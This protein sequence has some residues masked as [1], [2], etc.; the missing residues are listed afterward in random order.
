MFR[1]I[2]WSRRDFLK[3]AGILGTGLAL[4]GSTRL[5]ADEPAVIETPIDPQTLLPEIVDPDIRQGFEAATMKNILTTMVETE[6]PG[7]FWISGDGKSF[8]G[9]TWP[10]LDS[11]QMTGA[12]ML[13]GYKRIVLD[14]FE[15]VQ[16]SQRKDGH[17][18]FSIF[19]G[20]DE[21]DQTFGR[22]LDPKDVY[23]YAPKK[24][25]GQLA[26]SQMEP[27]KWIGMFKHWRI[28]SDPLGV[29]GPVSYL[30]TAGEIFNF[31]GSES[32]VKDKLATLEAAAKY[33][34]TK[35]NSAG[36]VAGSGYYIEKPARWGSDGVTQCYVVRAF[37]EMARL[38]RAVGDKAK[39]QLWLG[40]AEKL[41]KTFRDIFW[42]EDHFAEYVHVQRGVIDTHGL[43]DSNWAAVAFDVATDEQI[44]K[45]WPKL[46][47]DPDF[48]Y[49]G[50][51]TQIVTKPTT[52]E[53]WE[54]GEPM[55]FPIGP[56]LYDAAAMGRVWYLEAMACVRMKETKRLVES[57]RKV[58]QAGIKEGGYWYERYRVQPDGT[59]SHEGPKAYAEYA[60]I[61]TR[62]VLGNRNLFFKKQT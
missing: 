12:Y 38:F 34:L 2:D 7:F 61:L 51:P 44:A 62:V 35:K 30:L 33:I 46:M 15:F 50:M 39:E 4:A 25:P 19:P 26:V 45:L 58:S 11:W 1:S 10:G 13:L 57:V 28:E 56:E 42:R 20:D 41:A 17:I 6:Y 52:Y 27:R 23:T 8:A 5:L 54:Y 53:K 55:P 3:Q 40:H 22:T 31:V 14:Y 36:L 21:Y 18:P 9:A 47:N 60:A 29:L 37:R 48:W 59:V 49:G 32:W 16:A 43:S 24:R